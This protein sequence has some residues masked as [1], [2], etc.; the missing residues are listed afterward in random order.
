VCSVINLYKF[1]AAR[2]YYTVELIFSLPLGLELEFLSR[3]L[4]TPPL[5]T[6]TRDSAFWE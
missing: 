6:P 4:R 2:G 5:L 3:S 1:L